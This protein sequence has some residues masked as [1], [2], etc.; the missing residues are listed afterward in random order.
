LALLA[1]R[2][3]PNDATAVYNL[4]NQVKNAGND[5]WEDDSEDGIQEPLLDVS[6]AA[7][8]DP[9]LV[10]GSG[11]GGANTAPSVSITSP[12]DGASFPSG[13]SISFSGSASDPEDGDLTGSLVWTSSLVGQI[14]TGGS[15]SAVLSD[16]THTITASATDSGGLNSSASITVVVQPTAG[17]TVKVASLTGSSSTV[18]KNFWRATVVATIDPA[19]SGAL[20]SGSWDGSTAATCTTDSSGQCVMTINVRTKTGS[21]TFTVGNVT[22]TGYDYVPRV[23][24]VTVTY[25]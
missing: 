7:I 15:F 1:S 25:P 20:V 6:N 16:G 13:T 9:V 14:G 12:A 10:P 5:N 19:L 21:I 11:G 4:Y 8:F 18:N 23:T 17:N 3:N 24:S 2:N 22:L